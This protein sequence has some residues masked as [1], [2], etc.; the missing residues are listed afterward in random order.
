MRPRG[1]GARCGAR[2]ASPDTAGRRR[3][4]DAGAPRIQGRPLDPSG[5]R[6]RCLAGSSTG[7]PRRDC[8]WSPSH[9]V[10]RLLVVGGPEQAFDFRLRG[11]LLQEVSTELSVLNLDLI[12]RGAECVCDDGMKPV[13]RLF[14]MATILDRMHEVIPGSVG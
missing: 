12:E 6:C 4:P 13:A 14:G 5:E 10:L 8:P 7:C 2:G 1:R 9:T 11:L 3:G